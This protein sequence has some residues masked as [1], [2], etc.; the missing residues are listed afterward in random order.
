YRLHGLGECAI[1]DEPPPG[2]RPDAQE[3]HRQDPEVRAARARQGDRPSRL[4]A[5]H[6]PPNGMHRDAEMWQ[7]SAS[8]HHGRVL[9]RQALATFR[10]GTRVAM[11]GALSTATTSDA[12]MGGDK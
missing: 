7:R 5:A 10:Y 3:H 9:S 2:V 8:T 6:D 1:Q 12:T 11:S 4:T